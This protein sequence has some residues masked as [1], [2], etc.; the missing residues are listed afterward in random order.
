MAVENEHE[1][2]PGPD[3]ACGKTLFTTHLAGHLSCA[4]SRA[5]SGQPSPARH[6]GSVRLVGLARPV[7]PQTAPCRAA[8]A[9]MAR[10]AAPPFRTYGHARLVMHVWSRMSV[11]VSKD[12]SP[13][14]RTAGEAL[15]VHS[16]LPSPF[17]AP[18]PLRQ[19]STRSY[20]HALALTAGGLAHRAPRHRF[21]VLQLSRPGHTRVPTRT[22]AP[23]RL[24]R[25][26]IR[27]GSRLQP[28]P[29]RTW[30]APPR[31]PAAR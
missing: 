31:G 12:T 19:A 13:G 16:V 3:V 28:R 30:K 27:S 22:R 20:E 23:P 29:R 8:P 25:A 5:T 21:F 2:S 17:P 6:G 10:E 1:R 14:S 26:G 11:W 9:E 24:E 4:A 15:Q 7:R 18:G